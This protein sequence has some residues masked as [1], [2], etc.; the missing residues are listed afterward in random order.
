VEVTCLFIQISPETN[1]DFA[2]GDTTMSCELGHQG[3][4]WIGGGQSNALQYK[5]QGSIS[6]PKQRELFFEIA[7]LYTREG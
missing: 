5:P 3:Q 7:I 4:L 2:A 1:E 6:S